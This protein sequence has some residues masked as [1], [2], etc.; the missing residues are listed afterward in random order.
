LRKLWSRPSI[1]FEGRHFKVKDAALL[2]NQTKTQ[3]VDI[4]ITIA[5]KQDKTMQIAARYAQGWE[6][7][8]WDS[9]RV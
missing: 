4:P 8:S 5:A 2:K 7:F 9:L 6:S 3:N 1:K